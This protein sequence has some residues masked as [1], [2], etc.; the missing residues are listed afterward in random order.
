MADLWQIRQICHRSVAD[1]CNPYKLIV[2]SAC[3]V[4]KLIKVTRLGFEP[5]SSEY[6]PGALTT[7]LPDLGVSRWIVYVVMTYDLVEPA[8][9]NQAGASMSRSCVS[10]CD[11]VSVTDYMS[12][13]PP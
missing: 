12:N 6:I 3:C 9:G 2:T 4:L 1:F 8:V 7:E 13:T 5:R 10:Q 11:T